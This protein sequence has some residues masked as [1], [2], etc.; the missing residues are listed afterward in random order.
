[1]IW[2]ETVKE[3][4]VDVWRSEAERAS[5]VLVDKPGQ[6]RAVAEVEHELPAG[7][8]SA[9]LADRPIGAGLGAV[10]RRLVD[11]LALAVPE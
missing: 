5:N 4:E 3:D 11:A 6:Q 8:A 7:Q 2:G 9:A 10:L 1:M